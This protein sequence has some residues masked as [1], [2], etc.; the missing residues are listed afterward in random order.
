MLNPWILVTILTVF[1]VVV[2]LSRMVSL[3]SIS[4]AVA[5]PISTLIYGL[6]TNSS[7]VLIDTILAVLMAAMV[8]FMH[9]SNIERIKN[10]TESKLFEKK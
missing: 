7:D 3:A 10:G 5:F 8:I 6:S 2:A 1:G 9:R 4:A